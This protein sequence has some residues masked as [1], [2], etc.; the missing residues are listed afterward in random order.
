MANAMP[1]ARTIRSASDEAAAKPDSHNAPTI[2]SASDEGTSK[3][4]RHAL[5]QARESSS[6]PATGFAAQASRD[7]A[8]EA[9]EHSDQ[10]Y[11]SGGDANRQSSPETLAPV[12]AFGGVAMSGYGAACSEFM[13]QVQGA[14][15]RQGEFM[16]DMLQARSPSDVVVAGNRY[17]LG[18]LQDFFDG[19]VR[20]AQAASHRPEEPHQRRDRH[21]A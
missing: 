20:I 11:T 1:P 12:G 4:V 10:T 8:R 21:A 3:A 16:S 19:S 2:R 9:K 5:T 14:A 7:F 13:R 15:R 18:G 17:M 6:R